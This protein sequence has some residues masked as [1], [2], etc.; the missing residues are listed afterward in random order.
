MSEETT[1]RGFCP[2]ADDAPCL[3]H[4]AWFNDVKGEC[5]IVTLSRKV[6][7]CAYALHRIA[8]DDTMGTSEEAT[9]E[10]T[11]LDD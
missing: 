5:S 10:T 4:C 11:E 8:G 1:P 7:Q 9:E 3:A 6:A 2:L